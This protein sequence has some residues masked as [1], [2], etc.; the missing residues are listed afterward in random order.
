MTRIEP[1]ETIGLGGPMPATGH[2]RLRSF[3]RASLAYAVVVAAAAG[4]AAILVLASEGSPFDVLHALLK[5]SIGSGESLSQTTNATVPIVIVAIGATVA[6]RAGFL[7]VGQEGQATMGAMAAA[8]IA[9]R[10]A[11]PGP[12]VV[13]MALAASGVAGAVWAAPAALLRLKR[14][15]SEVITT[16]LLTFVSISAVSFAVNRNWLLQGNL[17]APQ[18]NVLSARYRFPKV[19]E[20]ITTSQ[21]P[22][23]WTAFRMPQCSSSERLKTNSKEI[24]KT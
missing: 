2:E 4:F 18:S 16:L 1:N 21:F 13:G 22:R 12:V 7:N 11:G 15:V 5:G 24:S 19:S 9:L 20:M 6:G 10:V 8:V 17:P 23:G 3:G 14:N